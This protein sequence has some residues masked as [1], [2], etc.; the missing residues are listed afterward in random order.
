MAQKRAQC[1]YNAIMIFV[2]DKIE[3]CVCVRDCLTSIYLEMKGL[4]QPQQPSQRNLALNLSKG[5][6][7]RC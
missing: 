2:I 4:V 7:F 1:E 3:L 5:V 6:E